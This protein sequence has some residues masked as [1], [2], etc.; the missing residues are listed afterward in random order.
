VPTFST[1]KQIDVVD[2]PSCVTVDDAVL[3]AILFS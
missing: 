3:N 2:L 1:A